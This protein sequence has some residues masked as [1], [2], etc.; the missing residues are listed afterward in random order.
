MHAQLIRERDKG[1]S[2]F[3]FSFRITSNGLALSKFLF[4]F[5]LC[6]VRASPLMWVIRKEEKR[7]KEQRK[8]KGKRRSLFSLIFFSWRPITYKYKKLVGRQE[9]IIREKRKKSDDSPF[10]WTDLMHGPPLKSKKTKE[11]CGGPCIGQFMSRKISI[12]GDAKDERPTI[13]SSVLCLMWCV[14]RS[15]ASLSATN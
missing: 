10:G 6:D 14:G 13:S 9:K 1:G 2:L 3:S 8:G 4:P 12:C 11:C 7:E 15:I 5:L